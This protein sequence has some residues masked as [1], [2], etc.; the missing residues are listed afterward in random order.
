MFHGRECRQSHLLSMLTTSI[1][2]KLR[3]YARDEVKTVNRCCGD[4]GK[5]METRARKWR[6]VRSRRGGEHGVQK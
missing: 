4:E 5:K 2:H 3:V 6:R 1:S